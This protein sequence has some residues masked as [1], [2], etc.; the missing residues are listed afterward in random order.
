LGIQSYRADDEEVQNEWLNSQEA[1]AGRGHTVES[2]A[3]MPRLEQQVEF[4]V[5]R[6]QRLVSPSVPAGGFML[7]Q[8]T[9]EY[10][11][12]IDWCWYGDFTKLRMC[13][14]RYFQL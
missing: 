6:L 12:A 3:F 13:K 11:R 9:P 4:L 5:G 10:Q 7:D 2:Q 14:I 1:E 8:G